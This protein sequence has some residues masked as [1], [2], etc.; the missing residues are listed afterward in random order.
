MFQ[1]WFTGFIFLMMIFYLNTSFQ[2]NSPAIRMRKAT[3]PNRAGYYPPNTIYMAVKDDSIDKYQQQ[4][5]EAIPA[6]QKLF[7]ITD[8]NCLELIQAE[9]PKYYQMVSHFKHGVQKSDFCRYLF[10]YHYGGTYID[11][12][13]VIKHDINEWMTDRPSKKINPTPIR[14]IVGLET[15]YPGYVVPGYMDPY[16]TVQ[17]TFSAYPKHDILLNAMDDILTNFEKNPSGFDSR[18]GIVNLTGPGAMTRA[19]QQYLFKN[20]GVKTDLNEV[21][22]VVGDLYIGTVLLF[23]CQDPICVRFAAVRHLFAGHWKQD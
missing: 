20:G 9:Y 10:I 4:A 21:P 22:L 14:M 16:Q 19:V 7:K 15:I 18:D 3:K 5:L 8:E 1:L 12:D 13:V 11:S 17:W 23:N 2:L 6:D